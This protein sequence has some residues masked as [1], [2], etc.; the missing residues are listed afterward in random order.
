MVLFLDRG[1][2]FPHFSFDLQRK[3]PAKSLVFPMVD[4]SDQHRK[5]SFFV[6]LVTLK[7]GQKSA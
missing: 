4:N 5:N 1:H 6:E 7:A 3:S 2:E